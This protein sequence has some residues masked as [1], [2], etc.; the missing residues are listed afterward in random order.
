[1]IDDSLY[2]H[3]SSKPLATGMIFEN[4]TDDDGRRTTTETTNDDD[5]DDDV[6]YGRRR[7][8]DTSRV[9]IGSVRDDGDDVFADL[10]S[11]RLESFLERIRRRRAR[12][13][14]ARE[15]VVGG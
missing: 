1:M 4:S 9:V 13:R 8:I 11:F 10:E 12:G 14:R 6:R 7:S 15:I 2:I 5:D 3:Q